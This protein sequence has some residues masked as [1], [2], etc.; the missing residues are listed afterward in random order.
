MYLNIIMPITRKDLAKGYNTR[1]KFQII[2]NINKQANELIYI[3][4]KH[5]ITKLT[6]R[7]CKY[8]DFNGK[9]NI[10][11]IN[12]VKGNL[13]YGIFILKSDLCK[14]SEILY[15]LVDIENKKKEREIQKRKD[16]EEMAK[17][18]LEKL[19]SKIP[20]N[21]IIKH[22]IEEIVNNE[23][24]Q[25]NVKENKYIR[26]LIKDLKKK[27][28]LE[29]IQNIKYI[30]LTVETCPMVIENPRVYIINNKNFY[31]I[32]GD[33]MTK[34]NIIKQIDPAYKVDELFDA[35]N[36]FME[37]IKVVEDSKKKDTEDM[38]KLESVV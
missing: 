6:F 4:E 5:K 14:E 13:R 9:V 8:S 32:L 24:I 31:L 27:F 25:E 12:E 26:T 36:E 28:I 34:S 15:D 38:P 16:D 10:L 23:K 22:D 3:C 33:M 2:K 21:E 35:Q 29:K 18:E 1:K 11:S 30:E 17:S 7:D 37:R 19:Q 20:N